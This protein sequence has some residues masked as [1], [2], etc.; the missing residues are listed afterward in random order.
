MGTTDSVK[1]DDLRIYN[2]ALSTGEVYELYASAQSLYLTGEC[3]D[4]TA[5]GTYY[6]QNPLYK[7]SSTLV[8]NFNFYYFG[9]Y[10][11]NGDH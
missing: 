5:T 2:R 1:L 3:N 11:G 8:S 9:N 10:L 6:S 7:G 4:T